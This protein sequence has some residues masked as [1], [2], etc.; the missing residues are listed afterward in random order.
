MTP[1][2]TYMRKWLFVVFAVGLF[3]CK[4][5][6]IDLSG[7]TPIKTKDL[8]AAFP[9]A[10]IPFVAA[11]SNIAQ[12][13]DTTVIGYKVFNQIIPD[14]IL[15]NFTGKD[16]NGLIYPVAKIVKEK[17]EYL[18]TSFVRNNKITLAVFVLD[19]KSKFLAAKELL[20][21]NDKDGYHHSVS[22]NREP[23]F[24]INK[25]KTGNN[26]QL[27][28]TRVGWAYNTSGFMVVVNETNEDIKKNNTI[29]NPIDTLPRK[30]KWSGNYVQDAKNFISIRDGKNANTYLFF[31]HFE[32]NAGDC[33]GELKGDLQI[34]NLNTAIYSNNGDPCVIDFSF[35]DNKVVVK[36]KGSCGNHRGIKCFFDDEYVKKKEVVV[37][38]KK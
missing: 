18:L 21:Q 12:I 29:L 2:V 35:L 22:I 10:E 7:N 14:S 15:Q 37:K 24:S 16:K 17:E 1:K 3:A 38:K 32:K 20:S 28:Y 23:T 31:I 34:K 8:I 19:K 25:D 30:N 27:L 33:I 36:E 9:D 11:D 26:N 4:D 6:K 5:K 13:G